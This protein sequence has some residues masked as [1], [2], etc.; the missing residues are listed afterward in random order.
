MT[1]EL[2]LPSNKK[3]GLSFALIFF[4]LSIYFFFKNYLIT[5]S[6]LFSLSLLFLILSFFFHKYLTHINFVWMKLGLML[7][8]I[9]SPLVMGMI[10]FLI[11]SPLAIIFKIFK[12]DEL[13]IKK[14]NSN[15]YWI[16]RENS[17]LTSFE[18]QY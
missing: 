13:K 5:F 2:I 17:E 16:I 18:N 4:L 6:L 12:R 9:I 1:D 8:K 10:F 3:F 7:G 15:S 11:F 14:I